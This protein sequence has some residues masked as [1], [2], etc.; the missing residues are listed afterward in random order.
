VTLARAQMKKALSPKNQT[1]LKAVQ[2]LKYLLY[3]RKAKRK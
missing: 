3:L 2:P 1:L